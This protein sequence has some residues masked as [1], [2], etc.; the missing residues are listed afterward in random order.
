MSGAIC[1]QCLGKSSGR[2][3][4]SVSWRYTLGDGA[5]LGQDWK[6]TRT[7]AWKSTCDSFL[8]KLMRSLF[9]EWI[10][11]VKDRNFEVT[12]RI[13]SVTKEDGKYSLCVNFDNDIVTIFKEVR[14]LQWLCASD[15]NKSRYRLPYTLTITVD[16]AKEKYPFAVALSETLRA[17]IA[18]G[19]V[20]SDMKPLIA[21]IERNV[22]SCIHNA[23]RKKIKG[24]AE[25]A[26]AVK[27]RSSVYAPRQ[28][29]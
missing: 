25:P 18:L 19:K 2:S 14:N 17:E 4:L 27:S 22:Q 5:V 9:D 1:R 23:F 28:G 8:R 20:P 6:S 11:N 13:F 24:F 7:V 3:R 16:E 26:I 12:G 29:D 15:T 10:A 21:S